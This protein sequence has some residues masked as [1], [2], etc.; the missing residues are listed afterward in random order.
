VKL[1]VNQAAIPPV[2]AGCFDAAG[3]VVGPD[4]YIQSQ[5]DVSC[6]MIRLSE[7]VCHADRLLTHVTR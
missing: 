3:E 7:N 2:P 5:V 4:P 6:H 1:V